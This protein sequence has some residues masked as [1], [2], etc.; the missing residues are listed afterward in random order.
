MSAIGRS[1]AFFEQP[2][3]RAA[4][5]ELLTDSCHERHLQREDQPVGGAEPFEGGRT[6][7]PQHRMDGAEEH[8]AEQC[9]A[10]NLRH[11]RDRPSS[12]GARR[13]IQRTSP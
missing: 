8:D 3:D 6:H 9:A 11:A 1:E 7:R 2:I 4:E 12:L 5:D 10:Q 13:S